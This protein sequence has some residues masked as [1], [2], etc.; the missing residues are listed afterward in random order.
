MS[1][2]RNFHHQDDGGDDDDDQDAIYY[3]CGWK[4]IIKLML[5]KSGFQGKEVNDGRFGSREN[6]GILRSKR[7]KSAYGSD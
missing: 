7:F 4:A 1:V 5:R 6:R 2:Y 3:S